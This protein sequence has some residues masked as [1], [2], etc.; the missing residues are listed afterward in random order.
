MYQEDFEG[1]GGAL[2]CMSMSVSV[3]KSPKAVEIAS[4]INLAGGIVPVIS[5]VVR[6][7]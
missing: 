4:I 7:D 1:S 2:I 6:M 3:A 5:S